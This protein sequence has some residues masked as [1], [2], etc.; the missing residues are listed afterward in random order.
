MNSRKW[1]ICFQKPFLLALRLEFASLSFPIPRRIVP[2]FWGL[3]L[4]V[5]IP[6]AH[7]KFSSSVAQKVWFRVGAYSKV[8]VQQNQK[9]ILSGESLT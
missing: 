3:P 2:E 9:P 4:R 7:F 5:P 1:Y 6:P 8:Q